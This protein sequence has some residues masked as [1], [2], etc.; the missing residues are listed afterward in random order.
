M[1]TVIAFISGIM[2]TVSAIAFA[3]SNGV[4]IFKPATPRQV[5]VKRYSFLN[6][7]DVGED[8]NRLTQ[9][10]FILKSAV[11]GESSMYCYWEKY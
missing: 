7:A 1:K 8:A 6:K 10:G 9:Q 2:L 3:Q 4:T 5:I 11:M